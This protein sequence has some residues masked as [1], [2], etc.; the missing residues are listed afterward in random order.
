[1]FENGYRSKFGLLDFFD[2]IL[3]QEITFYA[4]RNWK[5]WWK[6]SNEDFQSD[7]YVLC[8]EEIDAIEKMA[9]KST[10]NLS[11]ELLAKGIE[12]QDV[13]AVVSQSF[14]KQL[15]TFFRLRIIRRTEEQNRVKF[16]DLK[17]NNKMIKDEVFRALIVS[18]KF[19][20]IPPELLD[21]YN[22]SYLSRIQAIKRICEKHNITRDTFNWRRQTW[23]YTQLN[24][25]ERDYTNHENLDVAE[26]LTYTP[27]ENNNDY[28]TVMTMGT[29]DLLHE[30]HRNLIN[31]M[32]TYGGKLIIGVN[33]DDFT[34]SYKRVPKVNQDDRIKA[35][36]KY[37]EESL[38]VEC[39]VF[40]N[41]GYNNQPKHII[42]YNPDIF[43]I[44]EDW[45]DPELYGKQLYLGDDAEKWFEANFIELKYLPRLDGISTTQLL[46]QQGEQHA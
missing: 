38:N 42:Q 37:V 33:S 34:A 27:E 32:T 30:G 35:V 29:F 24:I 19:E 28:L 18:A 12:S 6:D 11:A 25:L 23:C 45:A 15:K 2:K 14:R 5:T 44:G 39:I 41:T 13:Q 9:F 46:E 17:N 4:A 26:Y 43:C 40:L 3:D 36:Q 10:T 8:L 31:T 1:M 16:M 22:L 20:N 7:L 21:F